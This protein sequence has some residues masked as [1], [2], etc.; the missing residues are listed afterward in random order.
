S[1]HP[2][3]H[4]L[5]LSCGAAVA[6]DCGDVQLMEARG[7]QLHEMARD[8]GFAFFSGNALA[9]MGWAA[10]KRGDAARG[11]E[12]LE[13]AAMFHAAVGFD[14]VSAYYLAWFAE[15][16]LAVKSAQRGL[17]AVDHGLRIMQVKISVFCEP[18]LHRLKGGLLLL[19]GDAAEAERSLRT[20]Y[21]VATDRRASLYTL[22]AALSLGHLLVDQGRKAEA[23][24]ILRDS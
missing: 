19:N 5:A 11:F 8:N 21:T 14:I 23:L 22:R 20:A 2:Y 3:L 17:A 9:F 15:A 7:T 13:Q 16:C 6:R 24:S 1:G 4:A 12:L 18:E 10:F